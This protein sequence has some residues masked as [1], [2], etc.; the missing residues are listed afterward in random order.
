[1]ITGATYRPSRATKIK[2]LASLLSQNN[3]KTALAMARGESEPDRLLEE[4]IHPERKILINDLASEYLQYQYSKKKVNIGEFQER[5]WKILRVRSSLGGPEEDYRIPPPDRPE[6]GHL[7]N[8]FRLGFG[9]RKG[10]LFEEVDFRPAY[11]NLL[12]NERGYLDG[13]QIVFADVA[14]RFYSS[15]PKLVLQKLDIIDITSLSPR[16]AFFKPYSWK[17]KT[18]LVQ[19][20]G[21][22]GEDHLVYQLNP[23]GGVSYTFHKRHLLYF[24][25]ETDLL[26]GSGLEGRHAVGIGA[27][28]GL[29]TRLTE[30]WKIHLCRRVIDYALGDK[31][32]AW[33][34]GFL[35][36]FT[37]GTN[38]S[39]RFELGLSR[40]YGYERAEAGLFW[41]IFF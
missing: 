14:L 40:M 7:S 19:Q 37:L 34:A 30:T 20:T 25:G 17:I 11:H 29:F 12:D 15:D 4:E 33:E 26:L 23:G 13:A 22:D 27:S 39:L 8:R 16:D 24:L 1:M 36:N 2:Y 21:P 6:E 35:R 32:K 41:N 10:R 28:A 3:G 18:G 9:V 38:T 5:F 31:H